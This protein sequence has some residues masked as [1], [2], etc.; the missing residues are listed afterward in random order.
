MLNILH[1]IIINTY[2]NLAM[3]TA[4]KHYTKFIFMYK[5]IN[6]LFV[7]YYIVSLYILNH[8]YRHHMYIYVYKTNSYALWLNLITWQ[9][10]SKEL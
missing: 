7:R 1:I 5:K 6:L 4:L 9:V 2:C 10:W 8:Y 3:L